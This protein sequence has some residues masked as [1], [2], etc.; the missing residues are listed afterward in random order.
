MIEL[1]HIIKRDVN[2]SFF[3][4]EF[5]KEFTKMHIV[6]LINIFFKYD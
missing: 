4:N 2:L 5:F 1:N 6:L 3:V